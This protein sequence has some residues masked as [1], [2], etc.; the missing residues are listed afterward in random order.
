MFFVL[1]KK[2]RKPEQM[3]DNSSNISMV[4]SKISYEL[5]FWFFSIEYSGKQKCKNTLRVEINQLYDG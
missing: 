3:E 2:I 4:Q 1:E 5:T